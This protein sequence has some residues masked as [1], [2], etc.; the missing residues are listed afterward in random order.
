MGLGHVRRN[1]LIAH[2]LSSSGPDAAVLLIG[3][4][5]RATAF[6]VPPR[7]D[8]LTLP[9]LRKNADGSYAARRLPQSLSSL[10]ALRSDVIRAA[11]ESFEPN[12]FIVDNVPRGAVRELD[13]SLAALRKSGKTRIVLGLRDVLDEPLAVEREWQRARN[14]DVIERYFDAVWVYGDPA[15]FDPVREYRLSSETARKVRY[16]GYLDQRARLRH[17][18]RPTAPT[19]GDLGIDESPLALCLVG[20]GQDGAGLA[21]AFARADLP[22][23][24]R[25]LILTGPFMDPEAQARLGEVVR[26][27]PRMRIVE[28]V[29][30]P[31][32][33]VARAERIVTMGGYNSTC[34]ALSL[35]KPALIVPRVRPR[36]EQWIRAERLRSLGLVDVLHP[37]RLTPEAISSWLSADVTPPANV[38]GRIDLD[39]LVRLPSLFE[40]VL[41]APLRAIRPPEEEVLSAAV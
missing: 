3:G 36:A 10:I 5:R 17:S 19:L 2:A 26:R 39:G 13:A 22:D 37:D 40:E 21:G 28:F 11:L 34:E 27:S 38:R 9:S 23:G 41:R 29:S 4:T 14:E 7:A 24:Y 15:V 1:L 35:E 20:G 31:A 33:I 16:T 6:P 25:G 8:L 30:E 18:G 12:V 32:H